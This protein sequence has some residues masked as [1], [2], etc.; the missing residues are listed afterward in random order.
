MPRSLR[1]IPLVLLAAASATPA[2]AQDGG[3]SVTILAGVA[4]LP[5]YA[6]SAGSMVIPFVGGRIQSGHRYFSVDGITA[7]ANLL[8]TAY[9]EAGPALGLNFGRKTGDLDA[10]AT[11]LAEVDA[12]LE[13]GGFLAASTGLTRPGDKLRLQVQALRGINGIHDGWLGSVS[14]GYAT[15]IG[16]STQVSLE[17]SASAMTRPYAQRYFGISTAEGQASGLAPHAAAQG[18]QDVGFSV[19]VV[20]MLSRHWLVTGVGGARR[21]VDEGGAS[22]LVRDAGGRAQLFLGAAVGYTF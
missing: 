16:T 17:A 12:G 9:F 11:G 10:R 22:P 3:T 21:M 18:L 2:A 20:Q 6:G 4:T 13:L 7:R 5:R 1:L 15:P 19:S 14:L 8:G